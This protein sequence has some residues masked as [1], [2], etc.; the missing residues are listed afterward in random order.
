MHK[1]PKKGIVALC[2]TR[3]APTTHISCLSATFLAFLANKLKHHTHAGT[4]MQSASVF[5]PVHR[6]GYHFCP[7]STGHRT[8]GSCF[9]NRTHGEHGGG[10]RPSLGFLKTF[11]ISTS[12]AARRRCC[13]AVCGGYAWYCFN[14]ARSSWLNYPTMLLH[15]LRRRRRLAGVGARFVCWA[16]ISK[17][18]T[19]KLHCNNDDHTV[20]KQNNDWFNLWK[21]VLSVDKLH[22]LLFLWLHYTDHWTKISLYLLLD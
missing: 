5:S 21:S 18:D 2:H 8:R 15:C 13:N 17:V 22:Q 19:P 4:S 12:V 6:V 9:V 14:R 16:T 7:N 1:P 3:L 10:E 11:S 20:G